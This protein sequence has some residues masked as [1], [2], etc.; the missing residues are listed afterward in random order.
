MHLLRLISLYVR[1][2]ILAPV[3][4]TLDSAIKWIIQLVSLILI[5]TL[6]ARDFSSAVSGYLSSLCSDRR[7]TAEDVSA[8]GQH[9]KFPPWEKRLVPRVMRRTQRSKTCRDNTVLNSNV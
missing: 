9:R 6:G 2:V 8:F 5:R 7:P 4:Q 1:L 3:V